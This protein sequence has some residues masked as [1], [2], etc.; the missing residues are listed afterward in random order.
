MGTT[1]GLRGIPTDP[2][3]EQIPTALTDA[4]HPAPPTVGAVHVLTFDGVDLACARIENVTP[5]F[6]TVRPC[7]ATGAGDDGRVGLAVLDATVAVL[8]DVIGG[9]V[10]E[11]AYVVEQVATTLRAP[12][13]SVWSGLNLRFD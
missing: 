5:D 13:W 2:P 12:L 10:D 3:R 1:S 7:W 6:V 11:S 8:T 9:R 4:A